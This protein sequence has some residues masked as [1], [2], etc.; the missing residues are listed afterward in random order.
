VSRGTDT[1]RQARPVRRNPFTATAHVAAAILTSVSVLFV[2]ALIVTAFVALV[3]K[4]GWWAPV[5]LVSFAA[6][7]FGVAWV[8]GRIHNWWKRAEATWDLQHSRR[9]SFANTTSKERIQ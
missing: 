4:S 7:L 6:F 9:S 1:P 8:A 3:E 5:I 2:V